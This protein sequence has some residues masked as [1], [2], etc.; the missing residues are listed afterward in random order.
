MFDLDCNEEVDTTLAVPL[1]P[2]A[3]AVDHTSRSDHNSHERTTM[4]S[5]NVSELKARLSSYLARVQQGEEIIIRDR[6]RPI[7]RLVPLH[8]GGDEDAEEAALVA[9][10]IVKL[11]AAESLPASFWNWKGGIGAQRA[12]K[13]VRD[14]RD[15]D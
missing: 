2:L 5:A 11:P 15:E 3:V 4:K 8:M 1:A 12:I 13:A 10:G 6:N 9:A 14:E 7:A